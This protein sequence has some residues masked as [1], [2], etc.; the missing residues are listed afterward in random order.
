[1]QLSRSYTTQL[2]FEIII[3]VFCPIRSKGRFNNLTTEVS[4]TERRNCDLSFPNINDQVIIQPEIDG[5]F[6]STSQQVLSL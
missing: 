1:M 5:V 4:I 6:L 2:V 3:F